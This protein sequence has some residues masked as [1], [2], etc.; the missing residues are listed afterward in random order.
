[1]DQRTFVRD[2]DSPEEV[3]LQED[4]QHLAKQPQILV[5]S[6]DLLLVVQ[7]GTNSLGFPVHKAVIALHSPVLAQILDDLSKEES[8]HDDGLLRLPM[9]DDSCSAIRL[10]LA[11]MYHP[12][13]PDT[14]PPNVFDTSDL[15]DRSALLQLCHKYEMV[16]ITMLLEADVLKPLYTMLEDSPEGD[17]YSYPLVQKVLA[18]MA[19]AEVCELTG[20]L[21]VC[22]AFLIAHFKSGD[23]EHQLIQAE[24]SA[25]SMSRIAEYFFSACRHGR[26]ARCSMELAYTTLSNSLLGASRGKDLATLRWLDYDSTKLQSQLEE[27]NSPI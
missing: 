9:P 13:G 24:L 27:P 5:S 10:A 22:E 21:V 2:T 6:V 18:F 20:A 25:S 1:M 7:Q 12:Q 19:I 15:V 3:E 17:D 11:Y 8:R 16:K 14:P 23:K 4:V 26:T